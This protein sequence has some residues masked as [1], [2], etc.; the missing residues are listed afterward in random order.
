MNPRIIN[1]ELIKS[2]LIQAMGELSFNLDPKVIASI[3]AHRELEDTELARD[4]LDSILENTDIASSE[5][6]PLC[7]DTGTQVFFIDIGSHV[8]IEGQSL[9]KLINEAVAEAAQKYYLRRSIVSDPLFKRVNSGDNTPAIIHYNIIEGDELVITMAQ[10]GGGAENM[11]RLYMMRPTASSE[12]IV[13]MV[14]QTVI[15]A[16][17]KAC[18]PLILGIGIGGNFETAALMAKQALFREVGSRHTDPEYADLELEI[19][20]RANATGIG[21]QGMGGKSTVL[22]VH[23]IKQACHIASLPLAVNLQ[24]HSHRHRVIRI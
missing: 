6:I 19:L 7:Q 18:P 3:K 10:K 20:N 16:G 4:V 1:S 23:I 11:S 17:G 8:L 13:Q 12:D 9:D 15:E 5:Q 24:C 21:P 2:K 14:N 22:D